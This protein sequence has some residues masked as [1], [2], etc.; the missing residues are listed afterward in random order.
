MPTALNRRDLLAAAVIGWG[1]E[2]SSLTRAQQADPPPAGVIVVTLLG[3]GSVQLTP[4][5]FGP[6]TLVEAGG[7]RLLFDAG[8]ACTLRLNQLRLPVGA[9][10]A[11]FLTH[12]HSDH[13]IGLPDFWLSGSI[14]VP[15][16]NR[17]QGLKV[18]GPPGTRRMCENLYAAFQDDIRIRRADESTPEIASSLIGTDFPEAE[19]TVFDESDVRVIAFP[20][21]HGPLIRPAVG[22]RIE[23]AGR[24]VLLS[25]DTKYDER[26]IRHGTNVD[27]LIHEVCTTPAGTEGFPIVQA[28]AAHHTSPDEIGRVFAAARPRMAATTHLVEIERL[29]QFPAVPTSEIELHVRRHWQ[30]PFAIGQDLMRFT[31]GE[32]VILQQLPRLET[33]WRG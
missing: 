29:P 5:R 14:Q 4:S 9:I 25:G 20:V 24:S 1:V 19:G 6:S 15:Y 12:F 17:K 3:T 18:F 33:S 7:L 31:V 32:K 26:V 28:V 10:D 16:L 8:R 13:V 30:G 23:H 2:S 11:A 27:L 22:Y 21:N